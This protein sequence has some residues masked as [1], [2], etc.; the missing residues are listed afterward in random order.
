MRDEYPGIPVIA[1]TATANEQV[2]SDVIDRLKINGCM[3]LTQSFNRP[4]LFYEIKS[5]KRNV[6]SDISAFI[7]DGRTKETGVIYCF[8]RR[9]CEEVAQELRDTYGLRARHYHAQMT[10]EDK[11]RAQSAWQNGDCEIIVATVCVT[12]TPVAFDPYSV[13]DCFWYGH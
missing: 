1:L 13:I 3:T 8:S 7:K 12:Y 2:M 9:K 10:P 11:A 6:V 5:K 4:N